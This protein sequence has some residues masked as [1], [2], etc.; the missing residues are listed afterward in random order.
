MFRSSFTLA[1]ATMAFAIPVAVRAQQ[2]DV[3]VMTPITR[4]EGIALLLESDPLGRVAVQRKRASMP[5]LPLFDDVDQR[6]WYAPYVEV[7]FEQKLVRAGRNA[8]FRPSDPLTREET[9]L[10]FVRAW[11]KKS[12]FVEF[13]T[14]GTMKPTAAS[15]LPSVARM[16][17]VRIPEAG[18]YVSRRRFDTLLMA[19]AGPGTAFEIPGSPGQAQSQLIASNFWQAQTQQP[20]A[21]IPVQPQQQPIVPT[22]QQALQQILPVQQPVAQPTTQPALVALLPSQPQVQYQAVPPT[23]PGTLSSV[24]TSVLEGSSD[25]VGAQPLSV[26]SASPLETTGS[27]L[28]AESQTFSISMPTLGIDNLQVIHPGDP[29]TSQGLLAP[30]KDGVGHLFSYP[31]RGGKILI[32]GHSSSYPWDVSPYTKIFRQIN[33]LPVGDTVT[34]SY[35]GR[36]FTYQVVEHRTVPA[37][38]MSAYQNEGDGE[39]LILYTCW[40]PNSIKQRY[41]VIATP[42]AAVAQR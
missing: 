24:P 23:S 18:Q 14:D 19:F 20:I 5:P 6:S 30:L 12:P 40:P 22:P 4:A 35:G 33:Q 17:G 26:L 10:L 3:A 27:P 32:Y 13:V 39:E 42:I 7:A 21:Q 8:R 25:P 41:L 34:V 38:D 28:F 1:V 29:F 37:G 9:M 2:V 31:G 16:Y 11:N 36:T 15:S